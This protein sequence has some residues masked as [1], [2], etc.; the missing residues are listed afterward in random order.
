VIDND[1]LDQTSLDETIEKVFEKLLR[2]LENPENSR[3][4]SSRGSILAL[5]ERR[6]LP[7]GVGFKSSKYKKMIGY[8][9]ILHYL[10]LEESV[11][12]YLF[13]DLK[14]FLEKSE[15]FWLTVLMDKD[16]FLK[17]L[18]KQKTMTRSDFFSG[19][20]SV[21]YLA[22]TI[23]LIT[24]K[25]EKKLWKVTR[26]VRRKG[27]HDKG[28]LPEKSESV[29]RDEIS[30]DYYFIAFQIELEQENLI[31]A[32]LASSLREYLSGGRVLTAEE[33]LLFHLEKGVKENV[34]NGI[35]RKSSIEDYIKQRELGEARVEEEEY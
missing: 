35:K 14:E 11:R 4:N 8:L 1:Y 20:C 23:Q 31:R 32:S 2:F 22:E 16:L 9:L 34:H 28:T 29:R 3:Q 12:C 13:L 26:P 17:Y 7:I 27:Y 30:K 18:L 24:L 21:K 10:D 6:E 25:F 15:H 33:M 19:I 5:S